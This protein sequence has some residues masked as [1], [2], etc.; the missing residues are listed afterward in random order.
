MLGTERELRKALTLGCR[1]L[2]ELGES[3]SPKPGVLALVFELRR[4]TKLMN[5]T[6][7]AGFTS[8]GPIQDA[9]KQAAMSVLSSMFLLSYIAGTPSKNLTAVIALRMATMT[10]LHGLSPQSPFGIMG[11]GFMQAALNDFP[12]SKDTCSIALDLTERI[13]GAEALAGRTQSLMHGLVAPWWEGKSIA[14][15]HPECVR[16]FHT[17]MAHGDIDQGFYNI[18]NHFGIGLIRGTPIVEINADF[19]KYIRA[20][21]EYQV[22]QTKAFSLSFWR[23]IRMLTGKGDHT[24]VDDNLDVTSLYE[25]TNKMP[26]SEIMTLCDYV[27]EA[28]AQLLLGTYGNNLEDDERRMAFMM[29]NFDS[30]ATQL[31]R[32]F[33]DMTLF[34]CCKILHK[35]AGQYQYFRFQRKMDKEL[36]MYH[37]YNAPIAMGPHLLLTAENMAD[38]PRQKTWEDIQQAYLEAMEVSR[39]NGGFIFVEAYGYEKLAKLADARQDRAKGMFYLQQALATYTRWGATVKITELTERLAVR[40]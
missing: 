40:R 11:F 12:G 6:K 27:Y 5:K 36:E 19:E 4:A 1:V 35:K 20:M 2:K 13:P 16:S 30:P 25:T 18:I 31:T 38:K 3:V 10:C 7:V 15:I 17:S 21:D 28:A 37:K 22:N 29:K 34:L 32:S 8:L 24:T 23:H 14:D 33:C 26:K 39:H 9:K